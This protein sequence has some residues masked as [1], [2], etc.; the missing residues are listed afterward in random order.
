MLVALVRTPL[1]PEVL[2]SIGS[3]WNRLGLI[4]MLSLSLSIC[5]LWAYLY[6]F[7]DLYAFSGLIYMLSGIL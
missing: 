3:Q 5:F 1:S 2:L 6:A 7:S 4:F